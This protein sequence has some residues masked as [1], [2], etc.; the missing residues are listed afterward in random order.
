MTED[1]EDVYGR[2][3]YSLHHIL[4]SHQSRMNQSPSYTMPNKEENRVMFL[5]SGIVL[6]TSG[7]TSVCPTLVATPAIHH[8][9]SEQRDVIAPAYVA[10]YTNLNAASVGESGGDQEQALSDAN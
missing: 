6:L 1:V 10:G 4:A 8:H 5:S 3:A 2:S 9:H 7:L